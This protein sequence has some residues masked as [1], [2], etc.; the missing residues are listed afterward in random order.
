MDASQLGDDVMLQDVDDDEVDEE[1][2]MVVHV[3]MVEIELDE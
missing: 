3:N 2:L 1:L